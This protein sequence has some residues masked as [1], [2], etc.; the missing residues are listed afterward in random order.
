M[1]I[2]CPPVRHPCFF[3][4]DFP[5]REELIAGSKN[6]EEI[7]KFIGVDS[8]GYL[9]LEGMLAPFRDRQAFCT[10]CFSGEY[11]LDVNRAQGKHA[12]ESYLPLLN[13]DPPARRN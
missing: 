5:T 3:G 7:R 8:L 12:L 1:R 9:S 6:V 13:F 4:I 2:S 11:P 10:A